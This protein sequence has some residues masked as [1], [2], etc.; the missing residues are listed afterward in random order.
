MLDLH[1]TL[2]YANYLKSLGWIVERKKGVYY[3][4]RKFPLIG[5]VI[6][7]QRPKIIDYQY[8]DV[9]AVKYRAFQ[10]II[11][12][13]L[14]ANC[15]L[16]STEGYKVSK[17]PYL[18]SKTLQLDLK[19]SEKEL[20][21]RMKKDCRSAI[22]KNNELRI[23]NYGRKIEKFRGNWKKTVGLKRYVP[24]LSHLKALNKSFAENA[25]FITNEEKEGRPAE[26]SAKAGAIFLKTKDVAHYWQA[27]TN[28]QARR[29]LVQ[30]KI[31]WEGILWAKAAGCK[32]FDFE[33]IFDN[34][35][36]NKSWLGFSHFKKSFGG[37][38]IEYPGCFV[39]NRLPWKFF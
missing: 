7:I 8:I 30:Y 31:V 37:K 6:K 36:P 26:A 38:E 24:P 14:T 13:N 29:A 25:L 35:F 39:K 2:Q 34:R 17:S 23:M 16:L 5:S 10:V 18:P 12:P 4:I 28:K 1:Q 3:F 33:G 21:K 32:I 20:L 19:K 9:L 15:R 22:R 11:E 27:F